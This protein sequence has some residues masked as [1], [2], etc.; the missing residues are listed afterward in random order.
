ML[1]EQL[2]FRYDIQLLFYNIM[3]KISERTINNICEYLK[4]VMVYC[5][6][7]FI[8]FLNGL[9]LSHVYNSYIIE[10]FQNYSSFTLHN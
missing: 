10:S 3:S 8:M 4:F 7:K 9:V 1:K 2:F 5:I 6:E